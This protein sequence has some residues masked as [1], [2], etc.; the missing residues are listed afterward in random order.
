MA[1]QPSMRCGILHHLRVDAGLQQLYQQAQ[2]R[3]VQP[4]IQDVRQRLHSVK[5]RLGLRAVLHFNIHI[6]LSM[7]DG[8]SSLAMMQPWI[9]A[10]LASSKNAFAINLTSLA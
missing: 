1:W 10:I 3:P 4:R 8:A 7:C 5:L 2:G 9:Q 6:P